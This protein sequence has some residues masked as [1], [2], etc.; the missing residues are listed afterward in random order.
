[1]MRTF[2]TNFAW[3][4]ATAAY[5]V[6]G[7]WNEDGKGESIW[8]RFA[9]TPGKIERNENGDIACDQ[10]HRYPEDFKSMQQ[11]GIKNYRFS[12]SWPRIYPLGKGEINQKGLDHYSRVVDSLLENGITP[13]I[14]LYHWDLPQALQDEGGWP[15]RALTDCFAQYAE[16]VVKTLGDRVKRWMTFNEP[17]VT[18]MVGYREGRFAPGICDQKQ[19]FQTAYHLILAH[20]KAY[21]AIKAVSPD[22]QV[23][24]AHAS[25]NGYAFSRDE[26][27]ISQLEYYQAEG[28]GIYLGP[29]LKG[30]YP[31]VILDQIGS[32]APAVHPD[33]LTIMHNTDFI[34]LQ[35]Y[36]DTIIGPKSVNFGGGRKYDFFETTEMGWAVTPLGFYE[37]LMMVKNDY[38][39]KEIVITENGSAWQD[40]LSPDGCVHDP[41]RQDYLVRH[42]G[43]VHRAINDGAPITGYFAWSFMDNFEWA[44]GYRPRFGLVYTEYA[45]QQ[46]YI[47]DSGHLYS[48]IMR[49]NGLEE[50]YNFPK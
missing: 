15:E 3:G 1:M 50:S 4:V 36:S 29:L 8:D 21:N 6:E 24:L 7:A 35:Y 41:R 47:K 26:T 25:F 22:A 31:Q 14:T 33:D 34:G 48:D 10:Y 39:A 19:G 49:A 16:T 28:N 27:T 9:H 17:S 37:H 44:S 20:G 18:A 32:D 23:G 11:M 42:L 13:W 2:P 38:G 5:Q 30:T 43:M 40:V 45:S 12:V 46:R